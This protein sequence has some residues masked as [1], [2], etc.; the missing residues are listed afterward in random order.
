MPQQPNVNRQITLASRPHGRPTL[1]NFSLRTVPV[2]EPQAGQMLLRTV[3]LSLDPYM[4]GRISRAKSYAAQVAIDGVMVGGCICRVETSHHPDYAEGD[5]VVHPSGWQDYSISDGNN[6][7][8]KLPTDMKHPSQALGILGMPGFTGY[9]GLLDIGKPQEGETV[10]VAAATGPVGSTVGQVA[11]LK[12]ARPVGIAGSE[13]KCRYAVETLG[14]DACINH[15]DPDFKEQL[16]QAC[17]D[18]IDVYFESVGGKIFDTILPLLN[19][20]ARIP[21]CGLVSQYNNTKLPDGPN[22]TTIVMSTLLTKRISMKGFIIFE[23]YGSHFP[24][25]YQQM[26][27]W[28][29]QGKIYCKEQM[30]QGLENAP[31]AFID[32]LDGKNFGKIVIQVGQ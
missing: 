21:L 12:G 1:E 6:I 11:K 15:K 27:Q 24:E 8:I 26:S 16:K 22:R 5:L 9:M 10:V 30:I 17:P 2:P 7:L 18:G 3:Y 29:E 23:D 20:K 4:R 32:L 31:Q 13:E 14:F 28:L 25:F 19:P